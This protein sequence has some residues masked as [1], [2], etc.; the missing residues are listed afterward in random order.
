MRVDTQYRP[1]FDTKVILAHAVGNAIVASILAYKNKEN[2]FSR[3][4]RKNGVGICHWH[5]YFDPKR[6]PKGIRA[7]GQKNP[8]VACSSPQSALYALGGKLSH[9][10]EQNG[11]NFYLGDVHIEPHHGINISY[12]SIESLAQ[13]LLDNPEASVLGNK[14][15]SR[16]NVV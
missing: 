2:E 16:Y 5:G 13:F 11:T 10:I 14:Y 4:V 7:Y 8:H 15:L 1:S 6:M 12:S 3:V 9:F